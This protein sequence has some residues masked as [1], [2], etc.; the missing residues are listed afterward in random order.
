VIHLDTGVAI[1]ATR[2]ASPSAVAVQRWLESRTPLAMCTMAWG[3]LLCGPLLPGE[4][5]FLRAAVADVVAVDAADVELAARLFNAT[6]RRRGS[7]ADCVIAASAIQRGAP[8][9]TTNASDFEPMST[10]GLDLI[11]LAA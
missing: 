10:F 1:H 11:A 3:E 5:T 2:V 7:F 8:L 4:E 9:A 6:G